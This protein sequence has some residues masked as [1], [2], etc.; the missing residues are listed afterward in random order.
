MT[1]TE[2]KSYFTQAKGD[3]SVMDISRAQKTP[4][5]LV[6]NEAKIKAERKIFDFF[7]IISRCHFFILPQMSNRKFLTSVIY[8]PL[9]CS[10]MAG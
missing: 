9:F 5:L 2:C 8:G 10:N 6:C 7:N 1:S 3:D 4:R